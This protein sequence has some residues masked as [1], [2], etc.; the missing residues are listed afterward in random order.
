[1]IK[2]LIVDDS[3]IV[4]QVL[5][6]EL[7]KTEDIVVVGTATDPYIARDKIVALCP[8]VVTLDI[9]MPRMD[10]LT[11]LAK[12]MK[13]YPLPVIVVSPASPDSGDAAVRALGLG[14]VDVISK[15]ENAQAVGDIA[16]TL[17]RRIRAA[18]RAR[19]RRPEQRKIGRSGGY[20]QFSRGPVAGKTLVIGASIGGTQAIERVMSVLPA[21]TPGTLIVQHMPE[22]FT[23]PFADRLNQI[24]RLEVREARG[25]EIL[26]PGLA[27][28]APG[29]RHL[30]LARS[31]TQ[32]LTRLADGPPVHH[33]R[34]SIEVL[35]NSVAKH[36]GAN[37]MGVLLTGMGVDGAHGL[38]AMRRAGAR[39][40]AQ[41][42]STSVVYGMP[43]AAVE[44]GAA[45]K[46]VPLDRIAETIIEIFWQ[47][48]RIGA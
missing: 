18:A 9:D 42:E 24:S 10:G 35:F 46:V 32:Y 4:R 2:V 28:V 36:A 48:E 15:P 21:E 3:A 16:E 29:N 44:L 25:G 12:L 45:E 38:L 26:Q 1:M 33:Q 23:G 11:F 27:L 13:Y 30:L 43:K 37:A 47:R 5:A 31:G 39:T 22:Y 6:A 19:I 40:M 14:A 34:P 41:D 17:V 20:R 8:D 7:A